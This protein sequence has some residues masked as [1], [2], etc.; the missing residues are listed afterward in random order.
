MTC[1]SKQEPTLKTELIVNGMKV[2]LNN[3]VQNFIGRAVVGML[4]SL[5]GVSNV[6]SVSL[7]I[8]KASG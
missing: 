3:F 1:E 5:R 8:S 4:T 7:K 6:E 2:E